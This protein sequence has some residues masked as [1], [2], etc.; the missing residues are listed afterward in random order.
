MNR[1]HQ[2]IWMI[3]GVALPVAWVHG[4]P[5]D[6]TSPCGYMYSLDYGVNWS[7]SEIAISTGNGANLPHGVMADTNWVH[8][9]AEPGAGTYARRA[10]PR[11]PMFTSILKTPNGVTLTWTN[12]A[13]LQQPPDRDRSVEYSHQ[14]AQSV[15]RR[16]GCR[17][18][19]LSRHCALV[20]N[21]TISES[22]DV[23][24]SVTGK[25]AIF[26]HKMC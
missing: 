26:I 17:K 21:Q 3:P 14:R 19:V 22:E 1:E 25:V 15:H 12:S 6:P 20:G 13:N 18:P 7:R 11:S 5:T 4:I 24:A 8:I 16:S 9:I 23:S 10:A 2:Q